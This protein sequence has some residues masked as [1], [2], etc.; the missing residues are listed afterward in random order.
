M[1]LSLIVLSR[2]FLAQSTLKMKSY[3]FYKIVAY[4]V[5]HLKIL[6]LKITYFF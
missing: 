5:T 4:T 2:F 1:Q 3:V 6:I